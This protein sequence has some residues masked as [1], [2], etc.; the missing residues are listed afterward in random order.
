MA[1]KDL[2]PDEEKLLLI[3]QQQIDELE[4][5]SSSGSLPLDECKKLQ[6]LH[7]SLNSI[8][9]K[10]IKD[11][12]KTTNLNISAEDLANYIDKLNHSTTPPLTLIKDDNNVDPG[13]A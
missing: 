10:N 9:G 1:N 13:R 3:I 2:T 7:D 6:I 5:K 11:E 4:I 8:I 12:D